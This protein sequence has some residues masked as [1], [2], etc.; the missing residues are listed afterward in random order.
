MDTSG[1]YRVDQDGIFHHAPNFVWAPT[2]ELYRDKK[3][4][5]TYPTQAGWRWFDSRAQAR[6]AFGLPEELVL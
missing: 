1:F 4:T 2:Y 5:Y 6:A 3:D